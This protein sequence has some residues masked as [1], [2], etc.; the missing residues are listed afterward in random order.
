MRARIPRP[1]PALVLATLCAALGAER[2]AAAQAELGGL[3][4]DPFDAPPPA[5]TPAAAP[6]G[7]RVRVESPAPGATLEARDHMVELHGTAVAAGGAEGQRFDV[8][9][10]LDV[11]QSTQYPSGAD[12]DGDGVVGENPAEGLYAPGEFPEGTV[13]TDPQDTILAAEVAA[14]R[15]LVRG[16]SADRARVG[17]L[18]FSGDVEPRDGPAAEPRAAERDARGAAHGRV[19][20]R[21]GRARSGARS[22]PAR[23]HRLLGRDP[24]RDDGARRALRRRELP[25]R[26]RAKGDPP[27]DRRAPDLPDRPG[28]GRRP[29]R[30]R[31][32]RERGEAR[33]RGGHP[34]QHLRARAERARAPG[35]RD[36]GGAH[37]PRHLHA[38]A[39]AGL[40]RRRA[41]VGVVRERRGR[42]GR[43]PDAAR[44]HARRAA[45]PGRELPGVRPGEAK[46]TTACS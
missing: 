25:G 2:P 33:A 34:D 18:T 15:A 13:C 28:L 22:G 21:G 42:G 31:G 23:R 29:G 27:P 26:R 8:M 10:A 37:D 19:R 41:P 35:R 14:A 6:R 12:V 4:A 39:R 45:Q 20:A 7:I 24:P 1:V 44:G 11:S 16:L 38:G 3:G 32:R 17:L 9:I 5:A 36:R 46:G 43:E 40:D 30:P